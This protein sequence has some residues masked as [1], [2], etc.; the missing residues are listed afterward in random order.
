MPLL[1]D[2]NKLFEQNSNIRRIIVNGNSVWPSK[3]INDSYTIV[4]TSTNN[5]MI[6]PYSTTGLTI[7]SHTFVNNVGTIV[8]DSL[9]P[10]IPKRFWYNKT[11]L[12]TVSYGSH[13]TFS[14][15]GYIHEGC[16]NLANVKLPNDLISLPQRMFRICEK[17]MSVSIPATVT[18]WG[19]YPFWKMGLKDGHHTPTVY[20]NNPVPI[21]CSSMGNWKYL[22][23]SEDPASSFN[24]NLNTPYFVVPASAYNDYV[25]DT[26]WGQLPNLSYA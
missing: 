9:T 24:S 3:P 11:T 15:E 4:Y 13:I 2:Y 12:E 18:N 14:S 22:F 21:D 6:T 10:S 23:I 5:A 1:Q 16:S 26:Y 19:A 7:L 8:I 20:V 25:N 17:L